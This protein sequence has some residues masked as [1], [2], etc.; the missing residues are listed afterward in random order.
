MNGTA[1]LLEVRR[2][3]KWYEIKGGVI[4]HLIGHVQAVTDVS[5][6]IG[7][8][9]VLGLAG[10]S[11]SG[12]TTI[13]RC[14]LRL[15]EPT[16][17][18]VLFEG[19]DIGTFGPER[20]RKFRR[21]AQVVF[22][23]PFGS[24]D[25]RMTVGE[26]VSEPLE[27]QKLFPNSKERRDRV[28]ELLET[29]ALSSEFL[30]RRP[31]ELSGGQRQRVG[32]ARAIAVNPMFIVADEPVSS[33]DVS[34][35]AQIV[36]LLEDLREK[37]GLAILFISHDIVVMEHLSNR[38]AVVYL[39]RVMEIGPTDELT[40]NPK[41]PYTEALLSAVPDPDPALRGKRIVLEGDIPNPVAPPSGCVFRTRCPRAIAECAA[42]IP[43]LRE[44]S[45]GRAAACIRL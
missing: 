24:L 35:Q 30:K 1:P 32:I 25:P 44:I 4:P 43:P 15:I 17:G 36:N 28:V 21:H 42:A 39:G 13:G 31:R 2:L 45:P 34:I 6:S 41:H 26:I 29:V 3:R 8:G 19:E 9:E 20:L 18:E 5:F 38:I 11:G 14:V 37:L 22:Q 23:D 12:K 16:S 27:V 10:E 7:R 40:S 33:L